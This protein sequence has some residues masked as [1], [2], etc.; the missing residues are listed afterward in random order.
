MKRD[1]F[2]R[3]MALLEERYQ[4]PQSAPMRDF[5]FS[6]VS[7]VPD[8]EFEALATAWLDS[9]HYWP[10]PADLRPK[11]SLIDGLEWLD[12]ALAGGD[13]RK[14]PKPVARVVRLMG[15]DRLRMTPLTE[16]Q[17]RRKEFER[18]WEHATDVERVHAALPEWTAEGKALVAEVMRGDD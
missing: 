2:D 14:A 18:L 9:K 6:R 3:V 16:V 15:G 8:A 1:T 7:E 11:P 12:T 10:N 13:W 17:F 4:R 5:Y